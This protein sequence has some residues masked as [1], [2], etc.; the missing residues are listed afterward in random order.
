MNQ[1]IVY[2]LASSTNHALYIGVT[3]ELMRT[4]AE[5]R[6]MGS[7]LPGQGPEKLVY[8]DPMAQAVDAIARKKQIQRWSWQKQVA[9]IN[10]ANPLWTDLSLSFDEDT[11]DRETPLKPLDIPEPPSLSLASQDEPDFP[12][13]SDSAAVPPVSSFQ[14]RR[15]PMIPHPSMEEMQIRLMVLQQEVRAKNIPVMLVFEGWGAAG[16]GTIISQLILNLDPRG[17]KVYSIQ[18]PNEQEKR[19]P[20]MYR[21]WDKLPAY[22]QIAIFDRS[23]YRDVTLAPLYDKVGK[24]G[25]RFQSIL[26]FE[27]QLATDGYV[28]A[29]FFLDITKKEQKSR[30]KELERHKATRWRVTDADWAHFK[31]HKK[32]G[33]RFKKMVSLTHKPYAPWFAIDAR[34]GKAALAA[35]YRAVIAQLELALSRVAAP[36]VPPL[37]QSARTAH[38]KPS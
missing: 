14:E 38:D 30:F 32:L 2:I 6:A 10:A 28:I 23:W 3:R 35:V 12:D 4:V 26:D 22:G 24:T 15:Q 13:S 33:R 29:K 20:P 36:V 1:Y 34:D 7:A 19:Y 25:R 27:Q 9:F 8:Y 18:A 31:D 11:A 37:G 16:K 17:F 21:F 5:Y